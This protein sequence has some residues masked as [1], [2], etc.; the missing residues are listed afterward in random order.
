MSIELNKEEIKERK[1]PG[2]LELKR[3]KI[4]CKDCGECATSYFKTDP[5]CQD[6]FDSRKQN[7]ERIKKEMQ[8]R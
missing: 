2:L 3:L 1:T 7:I 8:E 6:C 5:L 4:K